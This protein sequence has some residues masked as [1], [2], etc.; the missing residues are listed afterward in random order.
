MLVDV[1][2]RLQFLHNITVHKGVTTYLQVKIY[3]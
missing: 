2:S 1:G 3:V